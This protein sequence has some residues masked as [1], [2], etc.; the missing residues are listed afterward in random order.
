MGKS[1]CMVKPVFF[2]ATKD[3][4]RS[5]RLTMEPF[6]KQLINNLVSISFGTELE[7]NRGM[8]GGALHSYSQ[9]TAEIAHRSSMQCFNLG[10]S[11]RRG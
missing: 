5:G 2:Y 10:A 1:N 9:E 11:L 6:A 8:S 7:A 4:L 3:R